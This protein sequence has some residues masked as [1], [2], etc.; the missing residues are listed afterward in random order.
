MYGSD[1]ALFHQEVMGDIGGVSAL[2]VYLGV[3]GGHCLIGDA[4]VQQGE[5]LLQLG[6]LV[7]TLL[8]DKVDRVV[9]REEAGIILQLNQVKLGEKGVGGEGVDDVH[10]AAV[11][12][13][14]AHGHVQGVDLG[15]LGVEGGLQ[16]G[17][18]VL[19]LGEVG[20]TAQAEFG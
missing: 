16:T 9:G 11:D 8:T 13:G 18:G 15:E 6:I 12:G 19:P 5:H 3:H 2:E 4:A 14:V 7:Q 1:K 17:K 20:G 10:L